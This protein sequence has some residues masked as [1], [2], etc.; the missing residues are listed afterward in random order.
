MS[1][2]KAIFIPACIRSHVL[3]SFYLAELLS[4]EYEVVYAVCSEA[5]G[6]LCKKNGFRYFTLGGPKIGLGFEERYI[7]E[8][9][10]K[11]SFARL[12]KAYVTNELYWKRKDL[13][14]RIVR[15]WQ[16]DLVIIDVFMSTDFFV[17]K[18]YRSLNIA[19]FNPMPSIYTIDTFPS[20]SN[21]TETDTSYSEP[22]ILKVNLW[23]LI[24]GGK[25]SLLRLA[26][27]IQYFNLIKKVGLSGK[28]MPVRSK[29]TLLFKDVPELILLPE[30]FE[31]EL[32]AGKAHQFYLGLCQR[33]ERVDTE[34]DDSFCRNWPDILKKKANGERIVYCSF[35]TFFDRADRKLLNFIKLLS[36]TLGDFE[37]VHLVC[38]V[39]KYVID[40]INLEKQERDRISLF[41]KVPQTLVLQNAAAFITHGGMG[42]IKE[43]IFYEVPMIVF[44]LDLFYDQNS[45]AHK[46][47]FHKLG[48]RGV[49]DYER[50]DSL[51]QKMKDVLDND[52]Y[53]ESLRKFKGRVNDRYSIENLQVLIKMNVCIF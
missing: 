41:Y 27:D 51:K 4:E 20:F 7:K 8:K 39:N 12:F 46:V 33:N 43:S 19:F 22:E 38:S 17:L 11:V 10:G 21:G 31:Y 1:K 28:E 24:L 49:L 3:P 52:I 35:G 45:N 50:V 37:R 23:D 6:T 48:L 13:Y 40:A 34:L 44:P 2:K 15:D 53:R 36:T 18:Q 9:Y 16:P 25:Q 42:S 30:E 32:N 29:F 47:E 26:R 5:L 14:D